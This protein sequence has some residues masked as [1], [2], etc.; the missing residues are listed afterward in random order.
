MLKTLKAALHQEKSDATFESLTLDAV[1]NSH[2][3]DIMLEAMGDTEPNADAPD[4]E[5]EK[6]IA[7]IPETD[8]DDPEACDEIACNEVAGA[9]NKDGSTPLD[10]EGNEKKLSVDECIENYIPM[11][12]EQ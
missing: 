11:T 1:T 3:R 9:R 10:A 5:M 7:T 12:E 2:V 6:L 4:E 8:I